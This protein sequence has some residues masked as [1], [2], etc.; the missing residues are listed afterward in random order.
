[1]PTSLSQF[2]RIR[3]QLG[4]DDMTIPQT[5]TNRWFAEMRDR[6]AA[7]EAQAAQARKLVEEWR[8]YATHAWIADSAP[9]AYDA[10]ADQLAAI[11]PEAEKR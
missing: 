11:F 9:D 6:I 8:D 7:L 4:E 10:C 1:M 5:Q 2:K 3:T